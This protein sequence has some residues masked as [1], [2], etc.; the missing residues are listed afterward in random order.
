MSEGKILVKTQKEARINL[1]IISM[2]QLENL[3]YSDLMD[4]LLRKLFNDL[5]KGNIERKKCIEITRF[6]STL[7]TELDFRI[8]KNDIN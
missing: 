8:I 3:S 4:Q 7:G 1:K 5:N 6:L 2:S